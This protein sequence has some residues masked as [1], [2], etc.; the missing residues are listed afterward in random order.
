[1]CM[2]NLIA[3]LIYVYMQFIETPSYFV[4]IGHVCWQ[5]G[6][7]FPAFVYLFLNKTIQKDALLMLGMRRRKSLK[8]GSVAPSKATEH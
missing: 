3:A 8:T 1:M 5:L 2:A 6:H 4:L 7:G